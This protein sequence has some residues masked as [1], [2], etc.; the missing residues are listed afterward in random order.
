MNSL[1]MTCKDA[2][3][4]FLLARRAERLARPLVD[5]TGGAWDLSITTRLG[6]SRFTNPWHISIDAF[7][8][9]G[10]QQI[11]GIVH[12]PFQE[13]GISTSQHLEEVI[14]KMRRLVLLQVEANSQAGAVDA[15][16]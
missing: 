6:H 5:M 1:P 2:A 4:T 15:D 11:P 10:A 8:A 14:E 9:D 3:T 13:F 7:Y 12:M 16:D